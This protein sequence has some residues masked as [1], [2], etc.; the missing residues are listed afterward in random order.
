MQ[1]EP[2]DNPDVLIL[3]GSLA[4]AATAVQLK[5]ACPG[6]NIWILEKST[7]FERRVGEAT[8]EISAYF[9]SKT[10]GLT[11]HLNECHLLKQGLRFWFYNEFSKTLPDCSEIGG[12]YLPRLPAWQVDRSVLDAEL[13]E[14]AGSLGVKILRPA[15]V[16]RVE[17]TEGG[18]QRV[19]FEMDSLRRVQS[20]RWVVDATGFTAFL[21]RQQGWYQRNTTHP[22]R[23]VWS[24]WQGVL[25]WDSPLLNEQHPDWAAACPGIRSTATNHWMGDGWWAWCIP[26]KGGDTSIGIVWDPR[27]VDLPPGTNLAQRLLLFLRRH[28]AARAL[29]EN[30]TPVPGDACLRSQ[31]AFMSEVQAGDGFVLVGDAGGFLDPLYSPGMDWLAYT[32]QRATALILTPPEKRPLSSAIQQHNRD[33][34]RCYSRW[35]EAIYHNKYEMLGD[36]ELMDVVFRLD[37]GLYYLGV[38]SQVVKRGSKALEIP[39]FTVPQSTL[40][41]LW[42]RFYAGRLAAIARERRRRATLGRRNHGQRRLLQ[43]FVP[44]PSGSVG[45]LKAVLDY[46]RLELLEGWRTWFQPAAQ[47]ASAPSPAPTPTVSASGTPEK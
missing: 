20:A 41:F 2:T 45:V 28:P 39:V 37:L 6:L 38:V 43:G 25:D 14:Q 40:P 10:L 7:S 13:L 16:L 32:V 33:F 31:L 44:E 42:M 21:A 23:A 17:L 36:F 8:V 19:H 5:R 29:L 11:R 9:L 24:R 27:R 46:F 26:L 34:A 18:L 15:K 47:G 4:G 35:Y 12:R 22:T 3:G 30:A 1:T